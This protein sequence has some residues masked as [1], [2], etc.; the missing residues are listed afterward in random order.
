LIGRLRS[1]LAS[2]SA[3]IR[4][5]VAQ[6]WRSRASDEADGSAESPSADHIEY[7]SLQL[8]RRE[9]LLDGIC[10]ATVAFSISWAVVHLVTLLAQFSWKVAIS[11][12]LVLLLIPASLLANLTARR[13]GS[14]L[15]TALLLPAFILVITANTW[16]VEG[17]FAATAPLLILIV[18]M[19]GML[20]GPKGAYFLALIA[21]ALWMLTRA[22]L[23]RELISPGPLPD[24]ARGLLLV[25]IMILSFM[26]V[27][28]LNQLAT[29]DLRRALD[30]ATR[31]LILANQQLKQ[32]N[33]RKSQFT[34][35]TSHELR[36]PLS[37]IM[38]FTDLTLREVYGPLTP[39][40]TDK[41]ERVMRSAKRLNAL[42][43]DILDLSRIEA[44]ELDVHDTPFEVSSL[45]ES[46][47][48]SLDMAAKEK[49][50]RF[51]C[52]VSPSM[53][54]RILGDE[55]RLTQVLLN[56]A[57]NAVKFTKE[58][59]VDVLIE[60]VESL[61]WRLEV[62]DTGRGIC[63][64]NQSKVFDAFQ[65]EW[66]QGDETPGT[67]LGLTITRHLVQK[68]GGEIHLESK[69]GQGSRFEVVLPLAL[70]PTAEGQGSHA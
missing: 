20:S 37:A 50:L 62:K 2:S 54:C 46:V 28:L 58:G 63:P 27:A 53:P 64:E 39:K 18:I 43:G 14:R 13:Y 40:Q 51:S 49:G 25:A 69:L 65:Q 22:L 19:A 45:I 34:A 36:T 29:G 33:E 67:G 44:G 17:L 16:L 38:V 66:V 5:G 55:K 42:I 9:H 26:F 1:S 35:R 47:H 30:E 6:P 68:M 32:A 3:S 48:T 52:V 31:E 70:P 24:P 11:M 57:E 7:E 4:S 15:G 21:G 41:L 10:N 59:A 8:S 12:G 60:P 23:S 61:S 56:L